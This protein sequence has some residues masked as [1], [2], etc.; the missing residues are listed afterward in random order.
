MK[1]EDLHPKIEDIIKNCKPFLTMI[2]NNPK[3]IPVRDM[4]NFF[5]E[6]SDIVKIKTRPVRSGVKNI[7]TTKN[8]I[9]NTLEEYNIPS[10]YKHVVICSSLGKNTLFGFDANQAAYIIP[11]GTFKYAYIKDDFNN[12]YF[13]YVGRIYVGIMRLLKNNNL[14]EYVL[15]FEEDFKKSTIN[16]LAN[17]SERY[18]NFLLS[19]VD[20][21]EKIKV[22]D[23]HE[24]N[25]EIIEYIKKDYFSDDGIHTNDY[26]N[27][28]SKEHEIWFTCDAYYAIPYRNSELLQKL[29]NA[30]MKST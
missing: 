4:G 6:A 8:I 11:N 9:E 29:F 5:N 19:K 22:H 14:S 3:Y 16:T 24:Q 10:R 2:G 26:R 17:V 25:L 12:G 20:D 28:F 15:E 21:R 30:V 1:H 18:T 7:G 13:E 27:A 23:Y